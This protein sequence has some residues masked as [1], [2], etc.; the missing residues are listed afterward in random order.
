MGEQAGLNFYC[1]PVC[2]CLLCIVMGERSH[3]KFLIRY[4]Q[5]EQ[6][7]VSMSNKT[8]SRKQISPFLHK[9]MLI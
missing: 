2:F 6:A 7:F 5:S 9:N 4:G 3:S 1:S 8:V